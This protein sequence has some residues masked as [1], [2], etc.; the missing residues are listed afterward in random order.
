[1]PKP[2]IFISSTFYDLKHVRTSLEL[3]VEQLGFEP[4]LSE[5][6]SIA[7]DPDIPLDQSC[8]REVSS[9][10]IFVLIVG[11]RYG[12]EVSTDKAEHGSKF[13]ERY[14]SI[15]KREYETA[16]TRDIPTY[17]LVE[18]TVFSE[19]DTFKNNR[20]NDGIRY[21]H[22][23][24]VN[25]FHFLDFIL[26][27]PRNNP[28][29][30]FDR[31]TDIQSWLREQW[32]GLFRDLLSRRSESRQLTSLKE[33]VAQL[34]DLSTTL[35]R[36]LENVV[37]KV[38]GGDKGAETL[39]ENE[40]KRL[41][42]EQQKREA[43]KIQVLQELVVIYG[44][45]EDEVIKTYSEATSIDDLAKRVVNLWDDGDNYRTPLEHWRHNPRIVEDINQARRLLGKM[46]LNFE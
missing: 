44:I 11:G 27:R 35:K 13:R 19:Y 36:Y 40:Q 4:I 24:S 18:R 30:Q 1:M 3:F 10:D 8:Y 26:A 39:I 29:Y 46:P 37:S 42:T 25:V 22:V 16:A 38:G 14:E 17:I 20:D 9:T 31:H 21:A 32:A 2:R 23:D 45:S 41:I 43:L 15:T 12:S 7:Y 6:G 34:S 33:Q 28:I 5:K